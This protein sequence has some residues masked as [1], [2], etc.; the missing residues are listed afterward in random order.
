MKMAYT[1]G[2]PP[3]ILDDLVPRMIA[4]NKMKYLLGAVT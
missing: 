4:E 2:N 1:L 3:F